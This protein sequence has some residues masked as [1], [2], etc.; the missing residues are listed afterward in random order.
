M[1]KIIVLDDLSQEGLGLLRSAPGLTAEVRTGLKGDDLRVALREADGAICRSG[2]K[3]TAEILDGNTRLRAIARAGVGVDNIDI[4]TA[5]KQNIVVMNTPG[6][7][8][9]STAELTIALMLAMSRQIAP[10]YQSLCEGRWDRKKFMG[11]QL[12]G[13]TLG[14]VGLGRVGL[15]VV[16][17]ALGLE[18]RVIGF[19]PFVPP[20]RVEEFGV[21]PCASVAEMLPKVDYLTVHTT[22][23]PETKNL[24]GEKEVRMLKK[25][26]RLVNCARGGIYDEA[27]LAEGLRSGQLAGVAL[28]VYSEEPCTKSPLF[29]LPGAVCTP[30]LGASTVDAQDNVAVEAAELLIDFFK[31]GAIR[32]SVNMPARAGSGN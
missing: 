29:G 23:T 25:G 1:P 19:D 7:N 31:T 22:L 30:H 9:I 10:A 15:A 13:K 2:V 21:E 16:K 8:T 17:R 18:M 32:Q 24:I 4:K 12:A 14:V 6:G 27:A 5:T 28:D 20:A 11:V 26:A 3:I